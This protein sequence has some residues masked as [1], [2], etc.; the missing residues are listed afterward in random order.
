MLWYFALL[1]YGTM[2]HTGIIPPTI[3]SAFCVKLLHGINVEG[4]TYT[5]VYSNGALQ[6]Y[7]ESYLHRSVQ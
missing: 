1:S 7:T 5:T 3:P 2:G 4:V 6:N